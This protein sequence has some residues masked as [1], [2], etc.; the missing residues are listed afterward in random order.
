MHAYVH[1]HTYV[2]MCAHAYKKRMKEKERGRYRH[3]EA[4][5][6]LIIALLLGNIICTLQLTEPPKS[7]RVAQP[8]SYNYWDCY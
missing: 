3:R 1:A 7:E 8:K 6:S 4:D 2:H 5:E